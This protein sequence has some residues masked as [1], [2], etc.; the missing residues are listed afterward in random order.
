[1]LYKDSSPLNLLRPAE[2]GNDSY[3]EKVTDAFATLYKHL[4]GSSE[5]EQCKKTGMDVLV[6]EHSLCKFKGFKKYA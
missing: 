5:S 1:M 4:E 3:T 6:S 2:K